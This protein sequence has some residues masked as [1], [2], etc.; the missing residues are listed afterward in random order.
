M[1]T[2]L[3]QAKKLPQ[4]SGV[5]LFC[6]KKGNVLYVGR[7][8]LLRRRVLNYFQKY[9]DPRLKE[10]M[11]KTSSLKCFKTD[12]L[13]EAIILE[14]NLIK[15]YWPKYNIRE[16]DDRSFIY[17]VIPK[18]AFSHPIIIRGHEL[19]KFVPKNVYIFGP[20]KS[21]SL[22]ETAL[23]IIRRVFPYSACLSTR[24]LLTKKTKVNWG[25]PCL[26]Y[27]IGL[28]PGP[29]LGLISKKE[30]Q[31]NIDNFVLL[32]KGEQNK[33]LKR[34]KK[35]NPEKAEALKH[36]QDVALLKKEGWFLSKMN[37]IEGYDISH[38]GGKDTYG[39][40]VVFEGALPKKENYRLFKIKEAPQSDDLRALE[41]V[42]S[43]R[44][45]H[46]EWHL[47]DLIL[48]DG[49]R[50]QIEW[51]SKLFQ[52]KRI[53]IPFVGISKYQNDKLIFPKNTKTSLREMVVSMKETLLRVREESHRFAIF[54]SR[55][56]RK[57]K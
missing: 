4:E 31:K 17:I 30:Y 48:I 46:L 49:G 26:D 16:R 25:R 45:R 53:T 41:E 38:F 47:P 11:G 18:T 37:R 39:A 52:I 14:A 20:Y 34:L 24:A 7:A 23:K 51:V 12:N 50:P 27:Q 40:M 33:L 42:L 55:R 29:C 44:L 36:I 9:L 22:I 10:M 15:K 19:R 56:K 5:Y 1:G 13:L 6:D 8:V 32:L 43:R 28:C 35:E 3:K 57:Y 2:L 21:L 54:S